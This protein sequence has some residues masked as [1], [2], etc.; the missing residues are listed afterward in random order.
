LRLAR[1]AKGLSADELALKLNL[2][3]RKIHALEADN[4]DA[5]PA[6]LYVR[7][8]VK[9]IAGQLG[10]DARPLIA[11]YEAVRHDRDPEITAFMSGPPVQPT[12][13]SHWVQAVTALVVATLFLLL[14]LWWQTGGMGSYSVKRNTEQA[15]VGLH[16]ERVPLLVP[17]GILPESVGSAL[18]APVGAAEVP[19]RERASLGAIL[20]PEPA[21]RTDGILPLPTRLPATPVAEPP[22]ASGDE[23]TVQLKAET[24]VEVTDGRGR[25]LFYDLGH[26]GQRIG[27]SGTPPYRLVIGNAQATELFFREQAIDL[28]P[29]ARDGVAR[30]S[31]P[32][33]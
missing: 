29:Y 19:P 13:R 28:T 10:I 11:A 7:G 33:E 4:Y 9:A 14:A 15:D 26:G 6:T 2:D 17:G 25:R 32:L 5:M 12:S 1:E 20:G 21:L 24:W 23:I 27:V 22:A 18:L 16:S 30:L 3:V 31:L 8:Y